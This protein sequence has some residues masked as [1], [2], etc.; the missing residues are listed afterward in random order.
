VAGLAGSGVTELER[1][2]AGRQPEPGAGAGDRDRSK[3]RPCRSALGWPGG[4]SERLL[5]GGQRELPVDG[6][7]IRVGAG[8]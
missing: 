7:Q 1:G 8:A 2:K 6:D 4:E 5:E 3:V